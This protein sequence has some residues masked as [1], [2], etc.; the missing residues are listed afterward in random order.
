M[1]PFLTRI[2]IGILLVTKTSIGLAQHDSLVYLFDKNF[3]VCSPEKSIYT[4]IGIKE[5]G[6]IHFLNYIDSTGVLTIEG[7]FTDSTL[8]TREGYF[9]YY[10]NVGLKLLEGNFHNNK[11]DGVWISWNK[12]L[13]KDTVLRVGDSSYYSNGVVVS[14]IALQYHQNGE[15][16]S[17]SFND[18]RTKTRGTTTWN[19]NGTVAGIGLWV[20]GEGDDAHYYENGKTKSITHF[21]KK[22]KRSV[23][24]FAE[25]GHE[26]T[27]EELEDEEKQFQEELHAITEKAYKNVPYF[28]GGSAGFKNYLERRIKFPKS[29]ID[30]MPPG[31]K[32]VI[33]FYLNQDG[34]AYDVKTLSYQN[35]ELMD[36]IVTAFNG[37]PAW[38]MKGHKK[39][40][41]FTYTLNVTR[42]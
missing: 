27:K 22:N 31:E 16:Y 15:L 25:D 36:A 41:P 34:F 24:K 32:I 4:G 17:R 42:F 8:T 39:Y 19:D 11:E 40:G 7:F 23:R 21:T 9:I 1:N 35:S 14:S 2:L 18:S 10:D 38:D 33:S 28:S 13:L 37:M 3:N 5:N 29:F 30:Q 26:K 20:N 12:Q 6:R